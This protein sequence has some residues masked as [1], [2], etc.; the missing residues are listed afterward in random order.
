MR[1][2]GRALTFRFV[3]PPHAD[4]PDDREPD[5][6][7][8]DQLPEELWSAPLPPEDRLWRH[9]SEL[10]PER[11]PAGS[12]PPPPPAPPAGPPV[13]A[14]GATVAPRTG[15]LTGWATAAVSGVLGAIVAVGVIASTGVLEGD[16]PVRQTIVRERVAP[17]VAT[18]S[19]STD[20]LVVRVAAAAAPAIVRLEVRGEITGSGSGVLFRDDGHILTNAHVVAG[21]ERIVVVLADGTTLEA[22][23][24]GSDPLTDIAV[25]KASGPGPFPTAVLGTAD[26]L[27]V[28]QPAIAIGSP[29]GLLGGSSV[30]TG[31]VSALSREVSSGS[32]HP[33][34]D[35][36][37]TD[38]VIAPGSSGGALLDVGGSVIGITTAI[39][40]SDEGAEGLGFAVPIDLAARVGSQIIERGRALH[41]WLGVEGR[42][43]DAAAAV[44]AGRDGGAE[45]TEVREDSPAKRA[46]L[47]PGDVVVAVDERRVL[48]MSQLV[49]I[50][51]EHAPGDVVSLTIL[52]DGDQRSVDVKLDERPPS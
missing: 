9:P 32:G 8:G 33:L 41:V 10:D 51:R 46:S 44:D 50:L 4:D 2:A 40:M 28:G 38:A 11:P 39:A 26:G 35:M 18:T 25:V 12:A 45:I 34:L 6:G 48:S 52:R 27:E 1:D 22:D 14:F 20:D 3:E 5:D 23:P 24:V 19:V 43:L 31:V 15:A 16:A 47:A 29:L 21:A 49:V 37:Q 30:S 42:D 36:I 7:A 17:A 13:P